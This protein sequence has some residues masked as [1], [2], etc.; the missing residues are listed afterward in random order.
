MRYMN[1]YSHI[2]FLIEELRKLLPKDSFAFRVKRAIGSALDYRLVEYPDRRETEFSS[3]FPVK[4]LFLWIS[5]NGGLDP[6]WLTNEDGSYLDDN[7]ENIPKAI[8]PSYSGVE[9]LA[10][11]GLWI[12]E[13][14][15]GLS[16]PYD[17]DDYDDHRINPDG[18]KE[19]DVLNHKAECMLL[20][21]QALSYAQRLNHGTELSAEEEEKSAQFDFAAIG[22]DGAHKRHAPMNELRGWAI[23]LYKAG[24]WHSA[25][26]AAHDLKE[27]V[28]NYGRTINANLKP[29]NAQRTI[30]T[31]FSKSV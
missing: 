14:E 12:I 17:D 1:Q 28:M 29:S 4:A 21:Y 18:W 3:L 13:G 31:W 30:A 16:G 24:D 2:P 8:K 22:R 5:K 25:N 27:Q 15:F 10:A 20:A 6:E 19:A 23:N 7:G 11:Y 9:Q 26:E